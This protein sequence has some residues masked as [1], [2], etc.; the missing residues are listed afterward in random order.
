[1]ALTGSLSGK[2]AVVTGGTSGIGRATALC[3]KAAGARV[4]AT[5]VS[6]QEVGAALRDPAFEGIEGRVLDLTQG[7][8]VT[9]LFQSQDSLD[10]LVNAAGI[11][12]MGQAEFQPD[13]FIRVLD[14]NLVGTMRA[15]TAAHALLAQGGGA[16]VNISSIMG[17]MGCGM[18][19]GYATSKGGVLQLTR[20]LA[21]AWAQAGIRVNAVAPGFIETPMT[22]ALQA[23]EAGNDIVIGRTPM[24][25]W[26]RPGE[27]AAVIAFLCSPA[28]SYVT[29]AVVPVDGGYLA[30][31][32]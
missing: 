30:Y 19:P 29:G 22:T 15:C 25:R 16:I 8:A 24:K 14:I 11:G 4:L 6:E 5:G 28:A 12:G 21:V 31:G 10:I 27:V 3:L 20:S 23:N 32:A 13:A 1:M 18:A 2:F 7:E 9:Q 17:V 26:G